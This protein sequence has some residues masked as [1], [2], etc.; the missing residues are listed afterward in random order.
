MSAK[1]PRLKPSEILLPA[2]M[3]L[4]VEALNDVRFATLDFPYAKALD[5]FLQTLKARYNEKHNRRD[6][7]GLDFDKKPPWRQLSQAIMACCPVLV[8]AFEKYGNIYR[9][10]AI[11][12]IERHPQT[13]V[14]I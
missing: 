8:H 14:I 2:R 11:N 13:G 3:T 9:M 6:N 12:R 5:S 4:N 7:P 1:R 10:V